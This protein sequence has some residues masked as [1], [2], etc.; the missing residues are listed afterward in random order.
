MATRAE[1]NAQFLFSPAIVVTEGAVFGLGSNLSWDSYQRSLYIAQNAAFTRQ[2][3][4]L[5]Q[6]G[7]ITE[8]ETRIL[9]DQ[10]NA[11][12]KSA[13]KPLSPFGRLYSEILKPSAD[14]PTYERL[15]RGKGTDV[16]ILAS[17][18]KT[19]AVV[20]R[21]SVTMGVAGR[22][23]VFV[24]IA[25]SA[26]VIARAASEDRARIAAR[27][28]GALAGGAVGGWGGAWAGCA[29]ASLLASPSLVVPVI[30][31]ITTGGACRVGGIVGGFGGGALGAWAGSST[32]EAG[33]DYVT[34][35]EWKDQ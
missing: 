9:I 19:R 16:A 32:A 4:Q 26:V 28:S 34:R 24:S 1:G 5:L 33:F 22:G 7:L 3:N 27:E 29:G 6:R 20:N 8:A 15:I 14:L 12:I 10:R 31:E 25:L 13:R 21:L 11:L 17:V 18:G 35:L 23:M 30:G 2:A